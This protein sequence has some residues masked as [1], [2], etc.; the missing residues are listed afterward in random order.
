MNGNEEVI[1]N[2]LAIAWVTVGSLVIGAL[3]ARAVW[4]DHEPP[5]TRAETISRNKPH[6]ETTQEVVSPAE[7]RPLREFRQR[8]V[9]TVVTPTEEP[10]QLTPTRATE[11]DLIE[12]DKPRTEQTAQ[13]AST[14]VTAS[15]HVVETAPPASLV[16]VAAQHVEPLPPAADRAD[17]LLQKSSAHQRAVSGTT[18]RALTSEDPTLVPRRGGSRAEGEQQP[19]IPVGTNSTQSKQQRGKP[20]FGVG[21]REAN[22]SRVTTLYAGSTAARL[23]IK[24]GDRLLALD[25]SEVR[26]MDMLRAALASKRVG[27]PVAV[28]VLRDGKTLQLGPSLLRGR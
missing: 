26:S 14:S 9:A 25:G 7:K 19:G 13:H 10:R 8:T 17:Q 2:R 22:S 6:V 5:V 21:I 20:F 11:I 18:N 12:P 27:D 24:L 23:G 3:V 28:S 15:N 4:Q 1:T 16:P